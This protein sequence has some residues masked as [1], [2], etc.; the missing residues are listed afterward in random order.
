MGKESASGL[1][2]APVGPD[3]IQSH[4]HVL[5]AKALALRT[6]SKRKYPRTNKIKVR[7]QN[8]NK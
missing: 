3:W 4:T 8:E 1:V 5:N 7:I 2:N 6:I